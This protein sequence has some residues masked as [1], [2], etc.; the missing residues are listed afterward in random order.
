MADE[1]VCI[2]G[3][4]TDHDYRNVSA[5]AREVEDRSLVSQ[6]GFPCTDRPV[7]CDGYLPSDTILRDCVYGTTRT[8]A[9][10]KP[11]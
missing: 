5:V 8:M 2:G 1:V 11:V 6:Y 7:L 3:I 9:I 4:D 10:P